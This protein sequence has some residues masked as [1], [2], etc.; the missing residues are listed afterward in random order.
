[1]V[2]IVNFEDDQI[3]TMFGSSFEQHMITNDAEIPVLIVNRKNYGV[4]EVRQF[5]MG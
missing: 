5:K 4:F 3:L 2:A 1:M